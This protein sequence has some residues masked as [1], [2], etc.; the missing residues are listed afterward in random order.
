MKESI[1]KGLGFGLTSGVMTPL[2]LMV[3]LSVGTESKLVVVAGILTIAIADSLSDALGMHISQESVKKNT[4]KKI[5]ES[6]YSTF[7]FKLI[8]ALSFL[9]PVLFLNLTTAI[10]ISIVWSFLLLS[11]FSVYL[12]E[13]HKKKKWKVVAE[14]LIIASVIIIV[15]YF[16]GKF[17]KGFV[18]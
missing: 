17:L 14:H 16:L 3:G 8:I 1:K 12:A 5:W 10:L 4:S 13:E 15:T 2:G 9:I 11:I 6:T 7:F 18:V